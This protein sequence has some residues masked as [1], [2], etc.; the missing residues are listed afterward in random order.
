MVDMPASM[1]TYSRSS[2]GPSG[3][4]R[5]SPTPGSQPRPLPALGVSSATSSSSYCSQVEG[6]D[7]PA[8]MPA[9]PASRNCRF[10]FPMAS[11]V[12]V[13]ADGPPSK[14]PEVST[15]VGGPDG[16]MDVFDKDGR[17]LKQF[18][19]ATYDRLEG[20]GIP[21]ETPPC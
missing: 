2:K 5:S 13:W 8:S 17:L 20:A 16:Q 19:P 14:V 3:P 7:L 18:M 10:Q 15:Y 4:P 9:L 6:L 21:Q 11:S 12:T 1:R